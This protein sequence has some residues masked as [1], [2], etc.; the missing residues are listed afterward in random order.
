MKQ[1]TKTKIPE[2]W[3][4]KQIGD[5]CALSRGKGLSRDKLTPD[6]EFKCILYGE[7]FTIY[8]DVIRNVVS[9]TNSKESNPSKVGDIL[10]PGSTTTKGIDLAKALVVNE[11]GVLLG[12]DINVLRKKDY[13]YFPEFLARYLTHVKRVDIG[14]VAQGM[15][16]Y[17]LYG[18]DIKKLK[19]CIPKNI[20]EQKAI[21]KILSTADEVIQKVEDELKVTEKL[22]RGL[23]KKLLVDENLVKITEIFDVVGGTT[24]STKNKLYWE[25]PNVNWITPIDLGNLD[26]KMLI[27]ES[28]RKISK[29][30]LKEGNLHLMPKDTIIISTRAP[31]GYLAILEEE[32][33]FNQGCKGLSPLKGKKI[34]PFYYAYYLLSKKYQ[35]Q[36]RAGQS[37]FKEITKEMFEK[38]EIPDIDI[39]KQDKIAE[40]LSTVDKKIELQKSRKMTL[41][42]IKKGLMDELLTGK[43]RVNV[44]NI[45]EMK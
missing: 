22:K 20:D 45:L 36:N 5:I 43:K 41:E 39:S 9:R 10:I 16:I 35:L 31:V 8:N 7:L 15:T 34:N 4:E 19:I 12:G 29:L 11:N 25:N 21:A 28:E 2:G 1:Q 14:K 40:I 38:F 27:K 3:E 33:T 24:P 6:G 23:M 13:E 37:T 26:D 18:D 30:A 17:H 44:N 42:K 32:S